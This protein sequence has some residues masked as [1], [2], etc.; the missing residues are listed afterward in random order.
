M[1]L[2][3]FFIFNMKISCIHLQMCIYGTTKNDIIIMCVTRYC[4]LLFLT[5]KIRFRA[6][7]LQTQ[8]RKETKKM[9][10]N[11]SKMALVGND[12]GFCC[13][14]VLCAS[15]IHIL[16][17]IVFCVALSVSLLG[18]VAIRPMHHCKH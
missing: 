15:N 18:C 5:G 13:V 10:S 8:R 17:F 14:L 3:I 9:F 1:W 2:Q 7:T 11:F 16:Q 12:G 4:S 6:N